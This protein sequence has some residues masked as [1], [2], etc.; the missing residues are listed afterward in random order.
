MKNTFSRHFFALGL[1]AFASIAQGQL[2]INGVTDKTV[3]NDSATFTVV[4]QAG[5]NY[6][7]LL[8]TNT[9]P[10]GTPV[11]VTS[12][13]YHELRVSRANQT[14]LDVTNRLVRF[15]VRS[16]A[17]GSTEDGIPP[18]TPWPLINS[19]SNEFTGAHLR[20]M[21]PQDFPA[22]YE[23]PVVA[24]VE[25]NQGHAVRVNGLLTAPGHPAIQIKRGTG[26]GFLAATN[27][28]GALVYAAQVRQL[29]V[30]NA[31]NLESNVTWTSVSGTLSG[32]T[33]WLPDSRIAVTSSLTIPA[34]SSLSIGEGSVVRLN[35]SVDI[36]LNGQLSING[37]TN[38][39]VIF[40]PVSRAEPWG[41]FLLQAAT[42]QIT[43][44]GAV[45]VASGAVQ[46][47]FGSGGRPGSHRPEQ[48]LF[49]CSTT[50]T[51]SL[52]DCASIYLAGQ[53][54]HAVSGGTFTFNRFL[55]Q[56]TTSGGEYTDATFK[57]NDS[58]FIECPD[59]STNFVDGDND[60]LYFIRGTQ[61]FTNT[62]FGWTK[63]DGVDSGGSGAGLLNFQNCW[64]ESIFHEGNALSGTGK[65]VNHY[66]SV[67][68][69]CGQ[70]LESG[71]DGPVG[72]MA[73]CLAT[74]NL[75][76][77]RFGDNYNWTYT[78]FLR[79]TNS[80]L[81]YNYRDVWGMNWQDWTYRTNA[82]DIRSNFLSAPN[83]YHP[84]NTLWQPLADGWRL[85]SFQNT[86][87]G[88]DV[89][90]GFARGGTPLSYSAITDR[91]AVRLSSFSTNLVS[92]DFSL[93]LPGLTLATGTLQFQPG[94]TLKFIPDFA[95]PPDANIV[96][97]HL[98]NPIHAEI[99]SGDSFYIVR[100]VTPDMNLQLLPFG[101]DRVLFWTDP[102]AF[103]QQA[104]SLN[105]PWTDVPSAS[106][107]ELDL[108]GPQKFYRLRK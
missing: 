41:G 56:R 80:L 32:S 22:G 29:A 77:G 28:A 49:Y 73:G 84:S 33:V 8:D 18:W 15:I 87:P 64:F 108:S 7:V 12:V 105:S 51:L 57:V 71:Y 35:S 19:S 59:D 68:I 95:A 99:T 48:A 34:G 10:A 78:G 53:L 62:L 45:F 102:A 74:G 85:A 2:T 76:G 100:N 66:G 39:P 17:R 103:L 63:D 37:T 23:I 69:N 5:Y 14:T 81:L 4:T 27:P 24:W 86:P 44:T 36:N 43:A 94:E 97:V 82:M 75:V 101:S 91:L 89:G 31:I 47:W 58:A 55:M 16:S 6:S 83:I 30:T 11:A 96:R 92:V 20:L 93:D 42:S 52:V 38:R 98:G 90:L 21:V 104:D 70:G 67:F 9:A 107:V 88:A 40:M 54:G 106:P 61:G 26:S 72:T 46:N 3:Y 50:A 1:F 65:I 25:N 60:A 13:D 79:A